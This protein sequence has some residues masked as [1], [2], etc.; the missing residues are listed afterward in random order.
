MPKDILESRSHFLLA[1]KWGLRGYREIDASHSAA[2]TPHIFPARREG[3][4]EVHTFFHPNHASTLPE[5]YVRC[6]ARELGPRSGMC[7]KNESFRD[8]IRFRVGR[9]ALFR[10]SRW[11]VTYTFERKHTPEPRRY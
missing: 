1:P 2:P 3:S 8:V 9:C 5:P 11:R 4:G 6:D 10:E 7:Q